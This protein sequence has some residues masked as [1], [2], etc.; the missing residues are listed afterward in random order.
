[1]KNN[2]LYES[3]KEEARL[4]LSETKRFQTI[5]EKNPICHE[6]ADLLA[7]LRNRLNAF[8]HMT[9]EAG[10]AMRNEAESHASTIE[11]KKWKP[12]SRISSGERAK[13][14]AVKRGAILVRSA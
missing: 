7:S 6:A 10:R 4:I 13:R 1:M 14:Q 9:D 2:D 8:E 5:S 11:R 3:M 12:S